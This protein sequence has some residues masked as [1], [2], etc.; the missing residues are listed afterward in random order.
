MYGRRRAASAGS[1]HGG[2]LL[3]SPPKTRFR[4]LRTKQVR[5]AE[6]HGL[7]Q[8]QTRRRQSYHRAPIVIAGIAGCGFLATVIVG[9]MGLNKPTPL[10]RQFDRLAAEVGL[11]LSHIALSG[12]RMTSDKQIFAALGLDQAKS[13]LAFSSVD[14]SRSIRKLPWVKGVRIQRTFP[15]RLDVTIEERNRFAV[16][17][18]AGREF[19][20]DR[21]G[22]VLGEVHPGRIRTLPLV[23]GIG[24]PA[25]A[26]AIV[27]AIA[28]WPDLV[29]NVIQSER[30]LGRRWNLHL[31][32]GRRILLPEV[33]FEQALRKLMAGERGHRLFDY[34]FTLADFRIAGQLRLQPAARRSVSRDINSNIG[35][36]FR[37]W[38]AS[39]G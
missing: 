39:K 23:I 19:L 9:G 14:A 37:G 21:T 20:I 12:H 25:D 13:L 24:A 8:S 30:V 1:A 34:P 3:T 26:G 17:Q 10:L 36:R 32:D 15:H 33:D 22:H 35:Q 4:R 27:D 6:R 11:G 28:R 18:M 16:W 31:A 38:R 5:T 29:V 7:R 2:T